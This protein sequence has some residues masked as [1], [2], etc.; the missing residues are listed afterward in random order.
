MSQSVI[1]VFD[2]PKRVEGFPY[3]IYRKVCRM[4]T[5]APNPVS[6]SVA[7]LLPNLKD[8]D[9]DFR[10]MSLNDLYNILSTANYVV[11]VH[12]YNTSARAVEG[13]ITTLD[14]QNGEVQNLAIKW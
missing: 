5:P 13:V 2:T 3:L 12:D 8:T 7:A 11:L 6:S 1:A 9:A 14:D 4:A 10:F